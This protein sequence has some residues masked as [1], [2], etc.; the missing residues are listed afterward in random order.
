MCSHYEYLRNWEHYEKYFGVARPSTHGKLDM[1]PK[2]EGVFVRKAPEIDPHDEAVPGRE[3]VAG[4][5]GLVPWML[6]PENAS[7]Q[8]KLSTFNARVESVAKSFTFGDA[9]KRWQHCIV[10]V[11]AFTSLT[12]ERARPCVPGSHGRTTRRWALR[13]CGTYGRTLSKGRC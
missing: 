5:W 1:W 3:A 6:K 13:G 8:L 10:P 4:R 12:G 11:D 7:K 2:Y 9:W